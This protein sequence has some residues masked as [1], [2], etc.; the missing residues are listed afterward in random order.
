MGRAITILVFIT[1]HGIFLYGQGDSIAE[2][3]WVDS[4]FQSLS[5]DERAAQLL[6]VRANQPWKGYPDRI[7]RYIEEYNIGGITFFGGDPLQQAEITNYWQSLAKTPLLV[8]IDGEWGLG[9]R[10]GNTISFP[11]AMTLGAI[12]ED[13]LIYQMGREI[14]RQCKRLGIHMNFAPVADINSNPQ[15]PIIHMRSFGEDRQA[16]ARKASMYMKGLQDEGIVA[17]AKHF[18]GHGDTD[19]DSH[20]TLPVIN[21]NRKHLDSL[22]LYPFRKLITDGIEGVMVAHLYIPVLED[23]ENLATTLSPRVVTDL[24]RNELNFNGLV[25][26]DALDMS[27]VT[28]YHKAGDI[29]VMAL[30]AGNDILLLPEDVPRAVKAI[31]KAVDDGLVEKSM[32]EERCKKILRHKYRAG[33]NEYRKTDL[34]GL[35]EDLNPPE[36]K[37]LN[38]NLFRNAVTLVHNDGLLP[39]E[40]L[41]TLNIA[42]VSV[43]PEKRTTFQEYLSYY[44]TIDHYYLPGEPS[45][46]EVSRMT[47]Q[48]SDYNLVIVSVHAGNIWNTDNYGLSDAFLSFLDE[49]RKEKTVIL[50]IF[51]S[52]YALRRISGKYNLGAIIMSYQAHDLAQ[53]VSAQMVFGGMSFTARLPVSAGQAYPVKTGSA[54]TKTRLAYVFP[55]NAGISSGGLIPVDTLIRYCLDEKVFPGGQL[56]AA[57]NGEVFYNKSFGYQTYG[58]KREVRWDD[59]YD[60]ASLTKVAATTISVMKLHDKDWIDV[61]RP[62]SHYLPYLRNSNKSRIII[63]ETMAHQA[64]LQNWIPYFSYTIEDGKLDPAVYQDKI[65]ENYPVR[66]AEDLYITK[67]YRQQ[68]IDSIRWSPL[69]ADDSYKYSD[70][71]FYLLKEGIENI[72]NVPFEDYVD[73]AFYRRLGLQTTTFLPR[74]KFSLERIVPTENDRYFRKQLLRGDVH[75]QG[76]AMLG[77]VSGHAGLF[78]NANDMAIIMQMLLNEG[79]YGGIHYI[80]SATVHEFTR[81]QFPLNDNRRGIGFDKPMIEYEDDGPNCESASPASFGHAGFTGTYMWADPENG[82]VYVFLSNRVHPASSNN[83]IS[84]MNIRTG[85]H[86]LFYNAIEKK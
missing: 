36:A 80:D 82:L 22:E 31:R 52:P 54:T 38:L 21:H 75:D 57:R 46:R 19:T 69:R 6:M 39:L 26:T 16:V 3:R 85:L 67:N 14:G 17:V 86:Q 13:T 62:L 63:R 23:R 44:A 28:K 48:L 56:I 1:F 58:K 77:G 43:G 12:E 10:L 40:R 83:K 72:L 68:I 78:G 42:T 53:Q 29:E 51:G 64:R 60:L 41:D 5:D 30:L 84:E 15:N 76:A 24:L 2:S 18:P 27:G 34:D 9:M 25:V 73:T 70:L 7:R 74:K 81:L 37:A 45:T 20:K 59:I 50:D 35:L 11:Y 79:N 65:S 47:G 4:V 49:L 33:L 8:S 55:E 71:G 61:D 66:V 32:V